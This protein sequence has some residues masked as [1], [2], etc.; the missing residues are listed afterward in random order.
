MIVK[1]KISKLKKLVASGIVRDE[2][3]K[4]AQ[5]MELLATS[6]APYD[7][8]VTAEEIF[9][10]KTKVGAFVVAPTVSA[11]Q[12]E[13]GNKNHKPQPFMRPTFEKKAVQIAKNVENNIKKQL[14]RI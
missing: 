3:F 4:G 8:G 1:S 5:E 6:L 13:F 2:L 14:K 7:T 11:A 9:S 12:Q 10:F